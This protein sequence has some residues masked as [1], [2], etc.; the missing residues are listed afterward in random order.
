MLESYFLGD[1]QLYDRPI[2]SGELRIMMQDHDT[3]ILTGFEPFANFR[4]NSSWEAAKAL[5]HK[6][7]DSFT[8]RSFKI[9]LSYTEIRPSISRILDK[10]QPAIVI[11]LG[12]SY[13]ALI[14]L[15]K[16]AIN[17]ADLTE[18][19]VSYNCGT[20][21][22]DKLLDP[23]GPPAHFTTLP[24][25]KILNQLRH[26][27][28]PA[29]ISYTAGTFGCNHLFFETMRKVHTDRLS[30]PAGFIHVPCLPSQAVQMQKT[31][32]SKT[33]SMDLKTTTKAVEIAIKAT[34]NKAND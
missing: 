7:F 22:K 1:S 13:R 8:I 14:S 6:T 27:G 23:H 11:N 4:V 29:E 33:P 18:S 24:I 30:I 25:R 32:K 3:V 21:P 12:Q 5:D 19:S 31:G 9:P 28:I 15:E 16:V 26:N 20:Q 17:F 10:H 34:L 2:P